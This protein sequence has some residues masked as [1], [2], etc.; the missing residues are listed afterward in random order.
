MYN[1]R[2]ERSNVATITTETAAI[3]KHCADI[4]RNKTAAFCQSH[5]HTH[6]D[7]GM[8]SKTERYTQTDTH[9]HREILIRS[10]AVHTAKQVVTLD[11]K[12]YI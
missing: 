4:T 1:D 2:K 3:K 12:I 8:H 5:I 10:L 11:V 7:T 6:C 9:T